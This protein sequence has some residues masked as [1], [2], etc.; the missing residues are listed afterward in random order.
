LKNQIE[1]LNSSKVRIDNSV[2]F[3][4][5]ANPKDKDEV[6][7]H[8]YHAIISQNCLLWFTLN[9]CNDRPKFWTASRLA[10]LKLPNKWKVTNIE[11]EIVTEKSAEKSAPRLIKSTLMAGNGKVKKIITHYHYD[12]WLDHKPAPCDEMLLKCAKIAKQYLQETGKLVGINCRAGLGRTGVLANVVYGMIHID[13]EL[14]KGKSFDK[15][16]INPVELNYKL[17]EQR[18]GVVSHSPQFLQVY[19]ILGNYI[20]E[21]KS[22][23]SSK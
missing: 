2:N 13:Q 4:L 19:R 11:E 9:E 8:L 15:A 12:N 5:S 3:I 18:R 16:S 7:D 14:A 22:E 20:E 6:A 10:N 1:K 17:R 23:F 21:R